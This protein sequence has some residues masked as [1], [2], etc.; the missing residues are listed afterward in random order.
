MHLWPPARCV[1]RSD[2][3]EA[4]RKVDSSDLVFDFSLN[5]LL[6]VQS[7]QQGLTRKSC[8]SKRASGLLRGC[9]PREGSSTPTCSSRAVRRDRAHDPALPRPYLRSPIIARPEVDPAPAMCAHR[10]ETEEQIIPAC[11][12]IPQRLS[13]PTRASSRVRSSW[14]SRRRAPVPRWLSCIRMRTSGFTRDGASGCWL[15]C[16]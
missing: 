11:P 10:G 3:V 4:G 8:L 15:L 12:F 2:E 1:R 13:R 6:I 14:P 5:L 16:M 9:A 7:K